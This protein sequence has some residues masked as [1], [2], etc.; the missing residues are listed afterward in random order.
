MKKEKLG[1]HIIQLRGISYNLN[2]ISSHLREDF[3]PLIKANNIT[4]EGFN[5]K[6]LIYIKRNKIKNE[7][8]IKKG[9][10]VLTAL[11]GSK[12]GIGKSIFFDAD[13]NGSFGAF[14]KLIRPQKT[15]YPGYL[16]HFFKTPHYRWNIEKSVQGVK[17][18]N[19]KDEHIANMLIPI[20]ENYDD[21]IRICTV[22][23]KVELLIAKR[24]ESLCLLDELVNSTFHHMFGDPLKNEK[25]WEKK[26]ISSFSDVITGLPS[27]LLHKVDYIKG[28]HPLVNPSH[29]ID[30]K[31]KPNL[32]LTILTELFNELTKYH[33]S[34]GDI[35]L[36]RSGKMG[37]SA[38][39]T[40]NLIGLLCG[41]ESM[42]IRINN[43]CR[44]VFLQHQIANSSLKIVLEKAARGI[45]MK[46]INPSIV[47]ELM[48]VIPPLPIQEKFAQ[49]VEN[50]ESVR[51]KYEMSL[52]ELERLYNSLSHDAFLGKLDLSTISTKNLLKYK[53][54]LGGTFSMLETVKKFSKEELIAIVKSKSG[55]LFAFDE[56]WESIEAG[57]YEEFPKYDEVKKMVFTML[58]GESPLLSQV[59]DKEKEEIL[60]R[61]NI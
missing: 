2:E 21:Q 52:R 7:Q 60:L 45:A 3:I 6:D 15:L 29:I 11:N 8:L 48:V 35:V 20:P 22:L 37:K 28:G 40:D 23:S 47:E 39:V 53:I 41:K 17:V 61:L 13:F 59:F 55:N 10:V 36:G 32:K 16:K 1:K 5:K 38:V 19:L 18:N 58:G 33:L 56:L 31:I 25:G 54:D 27:R 24:K 42:I 14:C 9:D 4:E 46:T 50:I 12:K 51:I 43:G 34:V 49:A 44:P 30:G 26:R 57:S